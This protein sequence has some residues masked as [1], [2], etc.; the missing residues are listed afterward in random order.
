MTDAFAGILDYYRNLPLLAWALGA[1]IAA[2]WA[3]VFIEQRALTPVTVTLTAG[4]F[5]LYTP[6]FAFVIERVTHASL[7]EIVRGLGG[8]DP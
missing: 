8:E 4:M 7:T 3:T 1:I 2:Y 6:A 5:A